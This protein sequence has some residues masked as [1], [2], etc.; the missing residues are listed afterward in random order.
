MA[1]KKIYKTLYFW[2]LFGIAAGIIIGFIPQTKAFASGLEPLAKTFIKMVK[3]VIAPIIFCTVVTGI[4]KM[5]DMGKVGRVGL[6][7]MLYFWTMTLFA[8][9]IGL[10]VVNITKPGVGLDD[11][12]AKMQADAAGVKKVQ[13][14]AGETK[15]LSTVDFLTNIVPDSVVGAFSK[16]DILQVL[17][18][19]ILF[20]TGLSALGDRARNVM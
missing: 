7:A 15:K 14:Y 9:A 20:G 12:A 1:G 16:G 10:A 19:S 2:V 8:L 17:F 4:A 13:A 11:Y 18:F 5:G 6:K 3:M